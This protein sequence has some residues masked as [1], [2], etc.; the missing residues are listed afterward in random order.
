MQ[1]SQLGTQRN[2]HLNPTHFQ[3]FPKIGL[4]LG[5]TLSEPGLLYTFSQSLED[6]AQDMA[7]NRE[8]FITSVCATNQKPYI[9]NAIKVTSSFT[10]QGAKFRDTVGKIGRKQKCSGVASKVNRSRKGQ[11]THTGADGYI[12]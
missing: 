6:T 8:L 1:N 3:V 10:T 12:R 2:K 7:E 11:V 5:I 4:E 9:L